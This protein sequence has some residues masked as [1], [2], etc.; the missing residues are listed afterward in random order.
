MKKVACYYT[1]AYCFPLLLFS[2]IADTNLHL[3]SP[4]HALYFYVAILF[5]FVGLLPLIFI[6]WKLPEP[7]TIRE[8]EFSYMKYAQVCLLAPSIL[9]SMIAFTVVTYEHGIVLFV[10]S[11]LLF[12][13]AV[14]SLWFSI[15]IIESAFSLKFIAKKEEQQN[16]VKPY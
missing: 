15:S 9:Y 5:Q 7:E 8:R 13:L 10:G 12:S 14:L 1:L 3:L 4:V 2:I 16:I 6:I 11:L